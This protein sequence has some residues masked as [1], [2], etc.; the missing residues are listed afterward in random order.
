MS[1]LRHGKPGPELQDIVT[2]VFD[3]DSKQ[4]AQ[5]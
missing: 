3:Q 5:K 1:I 2:E 4:K